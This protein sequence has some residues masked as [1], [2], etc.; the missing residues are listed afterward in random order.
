MNVCLPFTTWIQ[1]QINGQTLISGLYNRD[2]RNNGLVARVSHF[3]QFAMLQP[4]VV[5]CSQ[6]ELALLLNS[7]VTPLELDG[8][9]IYLLNQ[10]ASSYAFFDLWNKHN[11]VI[12]GHGATIP[13]ASTA[14]EKGVLAFFQSKNVTLKNLIIR[15]GKATSGYGLGGGIWLFRSSATLE[16]MQLIDNTGQ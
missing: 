9:C 7:G 11:M 3:T 4:E 12:D 16:N 6:E 2:P 15:G 13:R 10:S 5:H 1:L 8:D 14:P